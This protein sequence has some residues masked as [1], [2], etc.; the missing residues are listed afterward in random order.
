MRTTRL[1]LI[2]LLISL[3]AQRLS[4]SV[5]VLLS[6]ELVSRMISWS[7]RFANYCEKQNA[8]GHY[9]LL[10][11]LSA[12]LQITKNDHNDSGYHY[13]PA[14]QSSNP[15]LKQTLVQEQNISV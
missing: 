15:C 2:F 9:P 10:N 8:T 5:E 3:L 4:A 12:L 7:E 14:L 11:P 13:K 1:Q 6:T